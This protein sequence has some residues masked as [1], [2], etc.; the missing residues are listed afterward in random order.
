MIGVNMKKVK[1]I[2][3]IIMILCIG[4]VVYMLLRENKITDA[5]KFSKEYTLVDKSNKFEYKTIDEIINI[6]KNGT[7]IV[8]LGFPS[9]PW[10]QK[11]V[12]YLNDVSKDL[13]IKSIY[14]FDIYNDRKEN[15][16]NYQ[17]I[18]NIL[19]DYLQ[20]NDERKKRVYVPS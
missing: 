11:Y 20:Y 7:G 8:Y 9:C 4:I 12:T 1:I 19:T 14:Y 6:L 2:S 13:K 10:C 17:E 16:K 3:I 18:V 15:T 5:E